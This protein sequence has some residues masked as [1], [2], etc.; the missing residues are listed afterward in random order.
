MPLSGRPPADLQFQVSLNP[1]DSASLP[2]WHIQIKGKIITKLSVRRSD[3]QETGGD[4]EDTRV[5]SG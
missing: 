3:H 5:T 1:E 2:M 4:L